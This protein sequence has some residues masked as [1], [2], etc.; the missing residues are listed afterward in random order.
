MNRPV[1]LLLSALLG[2]GLGLSAF[3]QEEPAPGPDAGQIKT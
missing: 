1:V 3:S 2:L